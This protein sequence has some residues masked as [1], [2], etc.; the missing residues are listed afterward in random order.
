MT[1]VDLKAGEDDY[2]R[3]M[4]EN[5][6]LKDKLQPI[7]VSNAFPDREILRTDDKLLNSYTS[8]PS[9]EIRDALC[10]FVAAHISH[11][12]ST[13]LSKFKQ[14]IMVLMKLRMNLS[15]FDLT[16]RFMVSESTVYRIFSRLIVILD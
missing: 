14:F 2:Q 11:T 9:S 4:S 13:K 7:A 10:R 5:L 3:H 1:F 16:F 6:E 8:L 15:L 12:T